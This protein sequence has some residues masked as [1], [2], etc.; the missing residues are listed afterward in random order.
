[1]DTLSQGG[2]GRQKDAPESANSKIDG[3]IGD[4]AIY[5]VRLQGE[6]GVALGLP[7]D[8]CL[9]LGMAP[10]Q[11][12]VAVRAVGP[13]LVITRATDVSSADSRLIEADA[14][15]ERAIAVW[16]RRKLR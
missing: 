2:T 15:I 9:S 5:K 11:S 14:E 13:C 4:V 8:V 10:G 12:Y 1:M 7:K 3:A 16:V 6:H